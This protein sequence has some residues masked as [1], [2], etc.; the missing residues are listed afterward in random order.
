MGIIPA[1]VG[2]LKLNYELLIGFVVLMLVILLRETSTEGKT[3][4]NNQIIGV[5]SLSFIN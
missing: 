5:K 1:T 2:P 3:S 4:K